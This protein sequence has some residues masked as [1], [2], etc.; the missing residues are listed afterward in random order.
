[1]YTIGKSN[2]KTDET[3]AVEEYNKYLRLQTSKIYLN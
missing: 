3:V 2:S 1:M